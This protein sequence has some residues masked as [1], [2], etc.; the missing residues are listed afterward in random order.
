MNVR[1]VRRGFW[2]VCITAGL[3]RSDKTGQSSHLKPQAHR[4]H[5]RFPV[6]AQG[7]EFSQVFLREPFWN[8]A[9]D[10]ALDKARARVSEPDSTIKFWFLEEAGIVLERVQLCDTSMSYLPFPGN[11]V[12][13]SSFDCDCCSRVICCCVWERGIEVLFVFLR[14]S[15]VTYS[16]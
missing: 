14:H 2:S 4:Q 16:S 9:R 6:P 15:A 8:Y 13:S 3:W 12:L 10:H 5:K 11:G 7:L 1:C